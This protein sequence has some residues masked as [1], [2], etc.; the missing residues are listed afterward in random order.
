MNKSRGLFAPHLCTPLVSVF[1]LQTFSTPCAVQH[2]YLGRAPG[3][4]P[5]SA[6]RAAKPTSYDRHLIKRRTGVSRRRSSSAPLPENRAIHQH[7]IPQ[8]FT[9]CVYTLTPAIHNHFNFSSLRIL[10]AV[11]FFIFLFLQAVVEASM[12]LYF[13]PVKKIGQSPSA[14]M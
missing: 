7:P 8:S 11:A 5:S 10:C 12:L 3:L 4:R 14:T 13:F 2:G 9:A 1:S 6:R